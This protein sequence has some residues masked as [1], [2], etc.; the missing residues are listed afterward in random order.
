VPLDT[1]IDLDPKG[2]LHKKLLEALNARFRLSYQRMSRLHKAWR[3]AEDQFL[4][5]VPE[6]DVDSKRRKDRENK[7]TQSYTTIILPYTYAMLMSAHSYWTTVFLSRDPIFQYTGRHGETQ[8]NVQ[9]LEALIAYQVQVGKCLLPLY[10]WLL[11]A[12]KYGLGVVVNYQDE[13]DRWVAKNQSIPILNPF[14]GEVMGEDKKVVRQKIQGYHG[15]RVVNVRPYDYFPDPRCPLHSPDKG[16]YVGYISDI[17][18]NDLLAGEATGQYVNVKALKRRQDGTNAQ[19]FASD[20]MGSSR[21]QGS[22]RVELPNDQP[23]LQSDADLKNTGTYT[24]L[25]I[26]VRLVPSEWGLGNNNYPEIW[27]FTAKCSNATP[28]QNSTQALQLILGAIP[29]G[30]WHGK[31]PVHVLEMEPEAYAFAARGMPEIIGPIQHTLDWLLNSHMY[32][33][34]K[35]VNNQFVIDPSRI[36][37]RDILEPTQGNLIRLKA[38]AYGTDP[39]TAMRQLAVTD[40]TKS[41]VSDIGFMHD[42]AQRTLGVN[43]QIMGMVDTG[44]RKTAQEV[45]SSSTFGVNRMKTICEFMSA[46]GFETLSAALVAESQQF[47][48]QGMKLRVVGDLMQDVNAGFI[49]VTPEDVQGAY[50][51]VPVDG[52]MP[53]DR[54][55]QA[56]LWKEILANIAQMPQI[57]MEYDLGKIFAWTAKLAGLKN[58]TQFKVQVLPPGMAAPGNVIP[59]PTGRADMG[60]VGEPGQ[61]PGLGTSG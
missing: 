44:G 6:S 41:N 37:M 7:G 17:S 39:E 36:V 8:Q 22:P 1:S 12:G 18:Y 14:T 47:F 53:I 49:Q 25:T 11:D 59:M 24:I 10:F 31:F 9:A 48:D 16:E 60:R 23:F 26:Y 2:P 4:A 3:D 46:M 43:D 32:A 42:F 29:L 35:T 19:D 34:R 20:N 58:I 33:V 5:Y 50:D 56:N 54:F 40:I 51:Y 21:E 13:D 28:A 27:A 61:I 57:A 30:T 55:A 15:Q 45:R 38:N 52:T